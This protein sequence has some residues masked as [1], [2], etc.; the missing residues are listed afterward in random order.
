MN[1]IQIIKVFH[2]G[3]LKRKECRLVNYESLK[4][5]D[6]LITNDKREVYHDKYLSGNLSPIRPDILAKEIN[7][8][9]LFYVIRLFNNDIMLNRFISI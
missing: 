8:D 7:D 4:K 6:D 2:K 3:Q 1:V 5:I 9:E